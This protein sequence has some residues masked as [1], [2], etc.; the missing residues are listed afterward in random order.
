MLYSREGWGFRKFCSV[1]YSPTNQA[2]VKILSI[3]G[4]AGGSLISTM[5][6]IQVS[7]LSVFKLLPLFE[8]PTEQN[9]LGQHPL[10]T[11]DTVALYVHSVLFTI[12]A[13]LSLFG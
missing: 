9:L 5:G 6:W 7:Q 8:N 10:T 4:T 11:T 2:T 1:R 12:L 3:V 13:L